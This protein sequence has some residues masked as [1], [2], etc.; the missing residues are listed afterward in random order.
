MAFKAKLKM[1]RY[2]YI[3]AV[4]CLAAS[5]NKLELTP[6][7]R[8]SDADVWK[9]SSLVRLYV[10]S[11]Y[12]TMLHGFQ[13]DLLASA[14]DEVYNIHDYGSLQVVQ[15]G[16]LTE[17]NVGSLSAKVNYF[18]FAYSNLRDIN[19][20]FSKIDGAPVGDAFRDETK[21]EMKFLLEPEDGSIPM[22]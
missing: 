21:G 14:C 8:L 16:N 11:T 15:R 13:E 10:N 4:L 3:M 5:C 1:K 18:N 17:T 7:D 6:L 12:N 9:D 2:I 22:E 20:F 19:V